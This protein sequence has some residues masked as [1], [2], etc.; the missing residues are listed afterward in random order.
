MQI[1]KTKTLSALSALGL[2]MATLFAGHSIAA[3]DGALTANQTSGELS[4]TADVSAVLSITGL[5][6]ID[7]GTI[8]PGISLDVTDNE[9]VTDT[10]CAYSNGAFLL[11]LSSEKGSGTNYTMVGSGTGSSLNYD[12]KIEYA[13]ATS[14]TFTFSDVI[15]EALN[16]VEYGFFNYDSAYYTDQSCTSASG[17]EDNFRVTFKI[18]GAE[19]AAATPDSYSDTVTVIARVAPPIPS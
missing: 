15:G 3:T 12:L 10:F 8:S 11:S 1:N 7:F 2:S 18:S 19:A 14:G 13:D 4:V 5:A 6:D 9:E 16:G 17:T